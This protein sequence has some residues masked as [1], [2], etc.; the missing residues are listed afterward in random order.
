LLVASTLSRSSSC[1][2]AISRTVTRTQIT[3]RKTVRTHRWKF[4]E[5]IAVFSLGTEREDMIGFLHI[6]P[7]KCHACVELWSH[8]SVTGS[9]KEVRRR[10][11]SDMLWPESSANVFL[12]TGHA[13]LGAPDLSPIKPRLNAIVRLCGHIFCVA[14]HSPRLAKLKTASW[15][16]KHTQKQVVVSRTLTHAM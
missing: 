12:C 15:I 11:G 5:H 13:T 14:Y 16:E 2:K 6:R 4:Y 8:T 7:H 3:T 10:T 1:E 9:T